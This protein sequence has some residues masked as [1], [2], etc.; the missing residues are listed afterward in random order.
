M[1]PPTTDPCLN[2]SHLKFQRVNCNYWLA[3]RFHTWFNG[4]T[5]T[6][7]YIFFFFNIYWKI[8]GRLLSIPKWR[9]TKGFFIL[10]AVF[11]CCAPEPLSAHHIISS[12]S[13]IPQ[14]CLN[15]ILQLARAFFIF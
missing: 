14:I 1:K 15:K 11:G 8:E 10:K 13:M 5:L 2:I 4:S 9:C 12:A 3:I 6:S 7:Q